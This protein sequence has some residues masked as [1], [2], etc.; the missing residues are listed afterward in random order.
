MSWIEWIAAALGFANVGLLVRRSVWNYP[1]GLAMVS[2]YG[3][4]FW[5]ARLYGEAYLQVFFFAAQL[6]GW[7]LWLGMGDQDHG[8]PVGWLSFGERLLWA[9]G[10]ALGS[11]GLAL[12]M[13]RFTNASAPFVDGPITAASIAAQILLALR[14]T[15]NWVL[16]IAVDVVSIGL[17]LWRGLYPTAALYVA[18]LVLSV[19]G[20]QQWR[21]AAQAA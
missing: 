14:R 3:L 13:H 8:V 10:I 17:Y 11:T 9:G 7:L 12:T 2:L 5:D 18:F 20:L 19:L 6:W 15:E 1:F 4:I 21:K 16:W